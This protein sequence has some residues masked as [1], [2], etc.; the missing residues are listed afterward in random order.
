MPN[1]IFPVV[2]HPKNRKVERTNLWMRSLYLKDAHKK[3]STWLRFLLTAVI[4]AN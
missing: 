1:E 3:R 4:Y 2:Q